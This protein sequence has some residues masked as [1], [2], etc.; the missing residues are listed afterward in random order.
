[1]N[2]RFQAIHNWP[3]CSL[4]GVSYLVFPHRHEFHVR[5]ECEVSHNDRDIEIISLK[6]NLDAFIAE[7]YS[8]KNMGATSC[9]DI[10]ESIY[11]KFNASYVR[12]LEDGE[13][14]ASFERV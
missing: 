6:E 12:V 10:C 2:S 9:E 5:L 4:P 8:N 1:M 13:N 14:G 3:G 11:H 7:K